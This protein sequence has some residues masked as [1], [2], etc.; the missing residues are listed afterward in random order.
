M[1]VSNSA[2]GGNEKGGDWS[3]K[4]QKERGGDRL[5]DGGKC[6]ECSVPN[7]IPGRW[8]PSQEEESTSLQEATLDSR[9]LQDSQKRP[10]APTM[11]N[12]SRA[13]DDS[14]REKKFLPLRYPGEAIS[15]IE[16]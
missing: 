1:L 5:V 4:E 8:Y 7:S 9:D 11:D 2:K 13:L 14:V 12:N 10:E 15:D 16:S 3:T 6:Q